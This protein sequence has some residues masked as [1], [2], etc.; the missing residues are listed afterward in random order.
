MFPSSFVLDYIF[1]IGVITLAKKPHALGRLL[2]ILRGSIGET[3][4]ITPSTLGTDTEQ[5]ISSRERDTLIARIVTAT[6]GPVRQNGNAY[7]KYI[8]PMARQIAAKRLDAKA[9]EALAPEVKTAKE[10]VIPSILSPS[11][12]RDGQIAITSTSPL[13][14]KDENKRVTEL[15]EAHFNGTMKLSTKLPNWIHEGLYGAGAMPILVLPVTEIDTIINDPT[16]ILSKTKMYN[17]SEALGSGLVDGLGDVIAR[18]ESAT[19]L[20]IGDQKN[21][22]S[23]GTDRISLEALQPAFEAAV[24]TYLKE[25]TTP[26]KD[27]VHSYDRGK[28]KT[29]EVTSKIQ[30]FAV[31]VLEQLNIVDNSDVLKIDKAKKVTK[32][33]EMTQRMVNVYKTATLITVNPETKKSVDDPI[34]IELPPEC[35][36]PIF[37]PGTPSDHI[38]YFILLDEFGNPL[39]VTDEGPAIDLNDNRQGTPAALYKSFGFD[40]NNALKGTRATNEQTILMSSAYQTIVEAHLKARL[41]NSGLSNIYI[42][43]TSSIYRCMFARYLSQRKTKMLF[44]PRDLMSYLCFRYNEDGTGRSKIED[45]KFILSLKITILI[46]RVMTSMNSAINRKKININFTEQ[47][48]DPIQYMQMVEKEVID[49]GMTNFTYDPV[50]ITRTIA[51]RALTVVPKGIPGIENFEVSTE[52]NQSNDI[53]PDDGLM[54]DLNNMMILGLDVPPSAYNQLNEN[55]FSRSVATNNLFFSR[56]IAAYQVPVCEHVARHVQI[57]TQMSQPLKEAICKILSAGAPN[58]N[59][60]KEESGTTDHKYTIEEKFIDII[61]NIKATLPAPNLAPNKTE[62]EELNV[63]IGS[64]TTALG[65]LFDNDLGSKDDNPI[66]HIRSLVASEIVRDYMTKIGVSRDV[67]IPDLADPVFIKRLM[68]SRLNISNLAAGLKKT[69]EVTPPADPAASP[70]AQPF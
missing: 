55:E 28:L 9:I 51:Q 67:L 43:A 46:C 12:M 63:I 7:S 23:I 44:V 38:G 24:E 50:E 69:D 53:K 15:L 3:T 5:S 61:K 6:Q 59:A 17:G 14:T 37:T 41:K 20:G 19:I 16:A 25:I 8:Q 57:Y 36:I 27:V 56:R 33:A 60:P 31:G 54:D 66:A 65:A 13:V 58:K 18:I 49:K 52:P 39:R 29:A 40:D 64:I 42:G 22:S 26:K 62:F 30:Q 35:V 11:D 1:C 21:S 48:G 47:M 45:I 4:P 10:I 70:G 2:S 32:S 34:V 68:D